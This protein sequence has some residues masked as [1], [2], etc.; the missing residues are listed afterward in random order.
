MGRPWHFDLRPHCGEAGEV[1]HLA[2][3]FL[4]ANSINHGINLW[5][6]PVLQY[7]YYL[8]QI[9]ISVAPISNNSLF[10]R[11][12][13]NPFPFFFRRGLNATLS[14]DDPLMFHATTQPLLEEYTAARL[15]F[16]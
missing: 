14:T 7:L 3:S 13:D 8:T 12:K 15:V 4:V 9:G 2:T 10:L 5:H 6:S 16:G 11:L 1:H